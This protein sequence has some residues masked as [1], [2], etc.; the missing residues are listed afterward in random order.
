MLGLFFNTERHF[1]HK[2]YRGTI[3]LNKYQNFLDKSGVY[4]QT[5]YMFLSQNSYI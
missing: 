2:K 4:W 3:Q 1:T 5:L